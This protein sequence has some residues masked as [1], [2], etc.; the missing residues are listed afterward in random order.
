MH[1]SYAQRA[2]AL[3]L[4]LSAVVVAHADPAPNALPTGGQVV[5]GDAALQSLGSR[6]DI[7][8]R[9]DRV[10]LDWQSFDIGR[11]ATVSFS[12]PSSAAV[13]LNRVLSADPSEIFGRL[14]SNG[15]VF[16]SNP[17]GVLIGSD[18]RVDVGGL[19]ATSMR[20]GLDDFMSGNYRFT[21]GSGAV[22]N[23][24]EVHAAEGGLLALMAPEVRNEG[25]LSARLGTIALAAGE[26]VTLQID[27][28]RNVA[29]QV[30]PA[31]IDVLLENRN[32]IDA[33]G[34]RVL[35]SASAAERLLETAIPGA[36]GATELVVSNG[37]AQLI[38]VAGT[39]RAGG[40][41]VD[42]GRVGVTR[43]GGTLDAASES[44]GGEISVT[45]DKIWI[46]SGAL[47]TANGG[48]SGQQIGGGGRVIVKADS[49]A[50]IDGTLTARGGEHGGDGGFI[51]TSG[52]WL[53]LESVPDAGAPAGQAGTW[54]IDPYNIT[55]QAMGANTSVGSSPNWAS[56]ADSA[57]LLTSSVESALNA[58][59]SVSITTGAGGSQGGDITVA[60]P[61][62]KTAGGAASLSFNAH[63]DIKVNAAIGSTN[64]A[65]SLSFN[66]DTNNDL[67]GAIIVAGNLTTL[68]GSIDFLDGTVV[69]GSSAL[70]INTSGGA[71]GNV[72]FGGQAFL[73]NAQGVTIATGGGNVTFSSLLDSGNSYAL[74]S[75]TSSWTA[76]RTAASSGTGLNVGD[77][78]LATITSPLEMSQAAA[79]ANYA[80]SWI[81]G[82][83]AAVEGTWRWVTG[84]EGLE[85]GGQGRVFTIGNRPGATP[86]LAGFVGVNGTYVNWN[87]GEP[88]DSN[89]EDSLQLGFGPAGQWNDFPVT[90][91]QPHVR[92]TVLAPS[93]LTINAGSG[94]ITFGG[95]VGANKALGT[96]T[97]NN[98]GN[99]NL[100]AN[101]VN[102]FGDIDLNGSGS[103]VIG[104][105]NSPT[106]F[107]D[108]G[109]IHVNRNIVKNAGADASLELR[110]DGAIA[111]ASGVG[112]VASSNKLNV[113]L[114][115]DRDGAGGGA[116][117]LA[118]GATINSNGGNVTLR[119][120]SASLGAVVDP[121]TDS[122]GFLSTLTATGASGNGSHGINLNGASIVAG[123]GNVELR[124]VGSNGFRG[125]NLVN[126][127][128]IAT[129]GTG[130]VA[131]HGVG[132]ASLAESDGVQ[133]T[134]SGTAVSTQDGELRIQGLG[135]GGNLSRGIEV[136]TPGTS[137]STTLSTVNGNMVLRGVSEATGTLDQGIMV[138]VFGSAETTGTGNIDFAG[139]GGGAGNG[140][141][142]H[143]L[144]NAVV[145][146]TG[147]GDLTFTGFGATALGG[148]NNEGVKVDS[149]LVEVQTGPNADLTFNG[150]GGGGNNFNIGVNVRVGGTVRMGATAGGV[151]TING[152]GGG[153]VLGA[154]GV[155]AELDGVYES[156]GAAPIHITG[157]EGVGSNNFGIK[158]T[159]GSANRIGSSTMTGDIT[160]TADTMDLEGFGNLTVQS[161]GAL[162]IQPN[163][164]GTSI[165][166]GDGAAGTLNL[167][168]VSLSRL[169]D[170]FSQITVGRADGIGAI[171]MQA[172]TFND[173][174]RL[175][176][177]G[178]G[179]AGISL[180]GPVA[181]GP[182]TLWLASSGPVTQTASFTANQLLL[183]GTGTF[184]LTNASNIVNTL[185]G[186]TGGG[187][188]YQNDGSLSVGSIAGD[189]T[190][191]SG[192]MS[193]GV[194][195]LRAAG[196][197]SDLTLLNGVTAV[198]SGT[199]LE[200]SAGGNFIN[201]AGAGALNPGAGRFLVWS[202]TPVNDTRGDIA[203]DF[204]QYAAMFGSTSP[205]QSSGNG[206]L[207]SVAPTITPTLMGTIS[208]V[209]D[210][211]T[212]VTVLPAN[213][214]AGGALDGDTV[215]LSF[216]SASFDTADAGPGKTVSVTGISMAAATNGAAPVYGYQFG[217]SS[218][219]GAIGEITPKGLTVTANDSSRIFGEANPSFSAHYDGFVTGQD[220]G[221]L[222]GS[223]ALT[224]PATAQS[225]AGT[226]AI[227]PSGL[228]ST[229]YA[230]SFV[231]GTLEVAPKAGGPEVPTVDLVSTTIG[232]TAF[233]GE[234][235]G[236]DLASASDVRRPASA[237]LTSGPPGRAAILD[238]GVAIAGAEA[239]ATLVAGGFV[240]VEP[241]GPFAVPTGA[242]AEFVVPTESFRHGDP[243]A[244]VTLAAF[245]ADGKP[246]PNGVSFDPQQRTLRVAPG[247]VHGEV[248][249]LLIAR[250][251]VGGEARTLVKLDSRDR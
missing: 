111:L 109:V 151:M 90:A 175:L 74:V 135:R 202:T 247:A 173:N 87:S 133:I 158:L 227:T 225:S 28:A 120:G 44:H 64:G 209:Y 237:A 162:A 37:T 67:A 217:S 167:N 35:L 20:I 112:I 99:V 132:G 211:T 148:A 164:P 188:E 187:V 53:D 203:Y 13:A 208:R 1:S 25:I 73:S 4:G 2:S 242:G 153:S 49:A 228:T 159:A 57:I 233:A 180:G 218:A 88:N 214:V 104:P 184:A 34:G 140:T 22:V 246:L 250:D 106:L 93:P 38:D 95:N 96:L 204:K 224:T 42:G 55:V 97:L 77:T 143:L 192:L 220:A 193:G 45:G 147:G 236:G 89:G 154:W 9:T 107:A 8:Q 12:Q 70:T 239:P 229:N 165:G 52:G 94:G 72:N 62:S 65:L 244:A 81:G 39:I 200:L 216:T 17:N 5:R 130:T 189:G 161:S 33:S 92:E 179:S 240:G 215:P 197:S 60:D 40:I 36:N 134:E 191:Y 69:A 194:V 114:N 152:S 71:G 131:L 31:Q 160:L 124:G 54:L 101:T 206:F 223:L 144:N 85:D 170:G 18:A 103:V 155:L 125:V 177:T 199:S 51:E 198:G 210:S 174:L 169:T 150:T 195:T 176:N 105:T 75:S 221:V 178:A 128:S 190:T 48:H 126:G 127:A 213:L 15:Q 115:S 207:Y 219:S 251:A 196:S 182:N 226:Y 82:S 185:A 47:L 68:G 10:V 116:I 23:R 205:A 27:G 163:T 84:P 137:S 183:T 232:E 119:G 19:V 41:T 129:T 43:V 234:V 235:R 24:G 117:S 29:V 83:D 172:A 241:V 123:G 230:I 79:A 156:L 21:Q 66:A 171:D 249:V 222:G 32:L 157:I 149:S 98:T 245:S 181:M 118:S 61:I 16:L 141:G 102:V 212:D 78:F 26:A 100:N 231:N 243:N 56:S 30:D 238:G 121:T 166:L 110:A 7:T 63:R 46:D 186:S 11:D 76:A 248:T 86:V 122:A 59:T 50:Q 145:R 113:T 3:L 139:R 201:S 58:G 138:E 108:D 146:T 14:S 142:V 136:D 6:L 80:S 168:A 91:L